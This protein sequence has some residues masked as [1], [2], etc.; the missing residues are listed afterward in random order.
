MSLL[1]NTAKKPLEEHMEKNERKQLLLSP[2]ISWSTAI[3]HK[4][5]VEDKV[6]R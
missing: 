6:K 5:N 4:S 3:S 1:A 2:Y